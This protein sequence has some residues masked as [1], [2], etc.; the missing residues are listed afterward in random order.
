MSEFNINLSA[1]EKKRLLTGGKYCPDDIVVEA[2]G[3][4]APA[5]VEEKD[6]NFYDY[7]GTLLYSYTLVE[8]QALTELPPLP[9]QPRL[10]CQGWTWTLDDLKVYAKPNDIMPY[11][12]TE[13]GATWYDLENDIGRGLAVTFRWRPLGG[14]VSLDFGDGS[15]IYTDA[16]TAIGSIAE[17]T[18][19]YAPGKYRAKLSGE[20]NL[21]GPGNAVSDVSE[22]VSICLR[23]VYLGEYPSELRSYTFRG[24]RCMDT[25]TFPL[26]VRISDTQVFF[27]CVNLRAMILAGGIKSNQTISS[28]VTA[29]C[30]VLRVMSIPNNIKRWYGSATMRSIKRICIPD[31]LLL[32]AGSMADAEALMHVNIPHNTITL[33]ANLFLRC[34]ALTDLT[35]P[36]S[37]TSIES[38][39]LLNCSVLMTLKF[40]P[41]TP[42][43]VANAN[44][45]GG[46][47]TSCVVEVPKGTLAAYQA[48]TNYATLSAQMVEAE[49]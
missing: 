43:T 26:A 44:A 19:V 35:I 17:I 31:D 41:T 39:A 20:Y 13:D 8:V 40:L 29:A 49:T 11:Y 18:H 48:A 27:E 30:T 45:F 5:A 2:E 42:P 12:V 4:G 1:G 15:E 14:A 22:S 6:V 34:K 16:S 28:S 23:K 32:A 46:I 24:C 47:P 10:I 36:S 37:V 38:Q 21:G 33:P 7:D 25:C 9:S 3:G